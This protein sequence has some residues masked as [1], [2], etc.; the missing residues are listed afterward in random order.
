MGCIFVGFFWRDILWGFRGERC[1]G[2]D[3]VGY[4][5]FGVFLLLDCGN[6]NDYERC[7]CRRPPPPDR[8]STTSQA[9]PTSNAG[10]SSRGHSAL[11]KSA[12]C[13]GTVPEP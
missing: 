12:V 1:L 3:F 9:A 7:P 13:L 4:C 6:A 8:K 2:F 5:L 10:Q 11:K